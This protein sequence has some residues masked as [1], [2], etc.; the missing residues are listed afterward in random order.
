MGVKE[1]SVRNAATRLSNRTR[2]P[3]SEIRKGQITC[4][5]ESAPRISVEV[6]CR[7]AE[8]EP[9]RENSQPANWDSGEYRKHK[10]VNQHLAKHCGTS[11]FM[12]RDK[13]QTAI[14]EGIPFVIRMAD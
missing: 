6:E 14:N 13:I 7:M 11:K 1:Q 12:S 3:K 4:A 10:L 9:C 8:L 5:W 2:N